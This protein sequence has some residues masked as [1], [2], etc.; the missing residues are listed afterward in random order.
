MV[1]EE[2]IIISRVIVYLDKLVQTVYL[3]DYFSFLE[4]ELCWGYL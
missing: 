2:K 1:G 4:S 3:K